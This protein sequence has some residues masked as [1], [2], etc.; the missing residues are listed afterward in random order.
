MG[1]QALGILLVG[2]RDGGVDARACG[3]GACE[4]HVEAR[5]A[6]AVSLHPVPRYGVKGW[7]AAAREAAHTQLED[8]IAANCPVAAQLEV[9]PAA[10]RLTTIEPMVGLN[11]LVT[12]RAL[13][14][15]SREKRAAAKGKQ[16]MVVV[17]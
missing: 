3:V 11:L 15:A 2:A 14:E 7:P 16:A 6:H 13:V 9:V 1:A 5:V 10:L 12:L 17:E 8:D 4:E